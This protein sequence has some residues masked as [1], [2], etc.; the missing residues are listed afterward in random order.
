MSELPPLT[1]KV[2]KGHNQS[3]SLQQYARTTTIQAIIDRL[4]ETS[5]LNP[6]GNYSLY[7]ASMGNDRWLNP[8][9]TLQESGLNSKVLSNCSLVK[10]NSSLIFHFIFF[11]LMN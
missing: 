2:R 8:K 1:L 7:S 9:H 5:F 10:Y 4:V 11:F 3:Y 6:E